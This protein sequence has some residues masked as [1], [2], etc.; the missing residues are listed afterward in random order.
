MAVVSNIPYYADGIEIAPL[1]KTDDNL[2]DLCLI[3]GKSGFGL[4]VHSL[5]FA[6]SPNYLENPSAH[7]RQ[8]SELEISSLGKT[9]L[10]VDGDLVEKNNYFKFGIADRKLNMLCSD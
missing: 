7:Y 8:I 6:N 9:F 1:A 4:L 10:Q 3:E 2:L 5:L